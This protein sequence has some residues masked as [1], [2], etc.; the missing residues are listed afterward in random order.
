MR[1]VGD[2][3]QINPLFSNAYLRRFLSSEKMKCRVLMKKRIEIGRLSLEQDMEVV[4]LLV[5][6][7]IRGCFDGLEYHADE[8]QRSQLYLHGWSTSYRVPTHTP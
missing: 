3:S 8:T 2:S 1:E 6:G 5:N 7:N 4:S